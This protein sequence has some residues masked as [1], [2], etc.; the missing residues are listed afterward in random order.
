MQAPAVELNLSAIRPRLRKMSDT[1]LAKYGRDAAYMA[2]PAASY[3]PPR[4]TWLLRLAEART[5]WRRRREASQAAQPALEP[6]QPPRSE[7]M[8]RLATARI[9]RRL[10]A[11]LRKLTKAA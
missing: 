10:N 6:V 1:R 2:S 11:E 3:G 9:V 8:G 5:V 4:A 7:P